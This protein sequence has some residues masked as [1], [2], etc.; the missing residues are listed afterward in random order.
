MQLHISL[1]CACLPCSVWGVSFPVTPAHWSSHPLSTVGSSTEHPQRKLIYLFIPRKGELVLPLF[2][3]TSTL[4]PSAPKP[5]RA[6]VSFWHHQGCCV[7]SFPLVPVRL[8]I[9]RVLF[10][11]EVAPKWLHP[12]LASLSS[13]AVWLWGQNS[14]FVW[15]SLPPNVPTST[16]KSLSSSSLKGKGAVQRLPHCRFKT[17]SRR[18]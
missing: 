16:P 7:F 2:S 13:N 9:T 4:S 18:W 12:P 17:L 14:L 15:I 8:I 6:P 1:A 10:Y 11:Q 3:A 5:A